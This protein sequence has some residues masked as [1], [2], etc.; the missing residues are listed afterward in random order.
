MAM[1]SSEEK[2]NP[3]T[4]TIS[5]RNGILS[6]CLKQDINLLIER[7]K[8]DKK[9]IMGAPIY[10]IY[11]NLAG[12][13]TIVSP[14]SCEQNPHLLALAVH[15]AWNIQKELQLKLN[16]ELLCVALDAVNDAVITVNKS[17]AII[18][19][20]LEAKKLFTGLDKDIIG[21]DIENVLGA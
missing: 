4:L 17:G 9:E 19:A 8:K 11:G 12:S 5:K 16:K 1:K 3:A 20:N 7:I 10:D 2:R 15:T 21:M 18:G 6:E 14:F 13:Y